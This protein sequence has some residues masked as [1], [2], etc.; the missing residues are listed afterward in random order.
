MH[1]GMS[2][3]TVT[4]ATNERTVGQITY[5]IEDVPLG[6]VLYSGSRAISP[7]EI[8]VDRREVSL[9]KGSPIY[10]IFPVDEFAKGYDKTIRFED[11]FVLKLHDD[12]KPREKRAFGFGLSA[13]REAT[14]TFSWEWFEVDRTGL[15][16]K[17]QERGRLQL[18]FE[19][20]DDRDEIVSMEFLTDVSFRIKFQG[21]GCLFGQAWPFVG[22]QW[23]INV[24]KG[25]CIRWP[26]G[27]L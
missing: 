23:R 27:E 22:S 10:W 26:L 12:L 21:G 5:E 18:G 16:R 19:R 20:V 25:S 17:R 11:G 6:R 9:P 1:N 14:Q 2:G 8:E 24:M 13:G 7:D 15:A 4:D 3:G